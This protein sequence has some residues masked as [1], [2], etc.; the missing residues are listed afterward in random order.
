MK[1]GCSLSFDFFLPLKKCNMYTNLIAVQ[2]LTNGV[3]A[4]LLDDLK[5]FCVINS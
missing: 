3:T 4:E 1:W 5:K 2:T